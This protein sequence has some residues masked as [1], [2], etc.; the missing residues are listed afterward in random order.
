MFDVSYGGDQIVEAVVRRALGPTDFQVSVSGPGGRNQTL[1]LRG[2]DYKGGERYGDV[3]GKYFGRVRATVPASFPPTSTTGTGA[4]PRPVI[5]GDTVTVTVRAGGQEQ[6]FSYRVVSTRQDAAKKRILVVAAEDYTGTAPNK[7]PY[8]SAPR[9]LAQHVDA[10]KAAGYEVDTYNIDAPAGTI[11]Y[12]TFLGVL[13]HF[14]GVLYYTGDDLVPQDPGMTNYRRLSSATALTGGTLISQWGAKGWFN[15]R[16]YLNEGGKLVIDGRNAHQTFAS[17]STGLTAYSGYQFNPDPFYGFNYPADNLGD[18]NRPGTAFIRQ[19]E[20]NNDI[21]QYF[22]GVGARQGGAGHDDVQHGA[23]R[24]DGGLD[25]R[26]RRAVHGRHRRR[27]TTRRRTSTATRPR[28]RSRSPACA[29]SRACSPA[30][31]LQQPLRQEKA[32]LDSQTTPAQTTA[33]GVAIST[34]DTVAFGFG[35]EQVD[36]ATREALRGQGVRLPAAGERRHDRSG[37][38]VHLPGRAQGGHARSTRSTSRSRA[39]TSAGTSR[40]CACSR[41][42]RS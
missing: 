31:R 35:L 36:Q 18:D 29:R 34:R 26:R 30:R 2:E 8:A 12:P 11:K 5:T 1:Y 40:R 39:T 6:V 16:D 19:H 13:S 4:L 15:L 33:G 28:A 9:Y 38:R 22:F 14:D 37:G 32:E 21:E 3:P 10:L 25:L 42:T 41:T 23:D 7:T 24:A 20:V 27:A 17:S